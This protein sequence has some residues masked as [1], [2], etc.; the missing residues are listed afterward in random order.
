MLKSLFAP[1]ELL[2][3]AWSRIW[4]QER[5][6]KPL[7]VVRIGLGSALLFHYA[8]A[9][10]Y[11]FMFWGDT[12]WM[13]REVALQYLD[14]PWM[15]SV[16]FYF[17]APWQWV[18]FHAIFLFSC[19]ALVVG[20]RTPIVK[21]IVLVGHIS[22]DY[23]N[24]TLSYG[25]QSIAACLL[26]ILCLAPIGRALS[27]DRVR[28][29]RRAKLGNL[30][31]IVPEYVSPWAGACTRLVQ[32]QMAVLF[33]Y[34]SIEKIR[35]DEW[36]SGD[37]VWSAFT[38]LEFYNAPLVWVVAHNY[39]LITI[40]TYATIFVELAYAFLIWQRSTRP[41]LLAAAVLLHVGFIVCLGLVY[42]SFLMMSG[43][44]SFL[45]KE[46]L[47]RLGAWWK[48]RAGGM[49]MI[50]DGRCGFCVRSMAWLLAFDG[51][52]QVRI[53]DFRSDPSPLVSDSQLEKALYAVLPDGRA[54]PGFEAYRYVVLRVPGLWWLVPLFYVPVL[55]RWVGHRLYGWVAANR[56]RLSAMRMRN[57]K[58]PLG[59]RFPRQREIAP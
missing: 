27:L 6:S 58:L 13:P 35:G 25:A 24:L 31:A 41:Y 39:W 21:W 55:S 43:H 4:F 36:W 46:W 2:W 53:R 45:R 56:S 49:E 18:A 10:P 50:Y 1:V 8:I 51:L 17:S 3:R 9:T 48:Q 42:F 57:L 37:A 29:V 47:A 11:L 30:N 33:F 52:A 15:Q 38:T 20:W 19:G 14:G 28:R 23:R 26:F 5:S 54:L 34:S 7:E 40:G 44:M 59:W 32:I 12:D 16:L 22:Y